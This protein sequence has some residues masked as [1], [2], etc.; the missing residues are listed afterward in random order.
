MQNLGIDFHK[1]RLEVERVILSGRNKVPA[2][3]LPRTPRV[4]KVLEY[5]I[6]EARNLGHEHV[7]TKHILLGLLRE[8]DCVAAQ[9]LM[10]CGLK[11]EDARTE[12]LALLGQGPPPG[13]PPLTERF[14]IR[15]KT[16]RTARETPS[17]PSCGG[18]NFTWGMPQGFKPL[19]FLSDSSTGL[20]KFFSAGQ[21]IK[22]RKCD[23][24]G[25][26][27]LFVVDS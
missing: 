9:V 11:L 22:A 4:K 7:G 19:R 27:Q 10:N 13:S 21:K 8:Q 24:C 3:E 2:G 1:V 12:L 16:D 25:N 26:V 18:D 17:C 15:E 20:A 14:Q 23:S 6:E 5:S